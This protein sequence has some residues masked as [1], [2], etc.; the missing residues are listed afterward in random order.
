MV[1][2]DKGYVS[3]RRLTSFLEGLKEL[4]ITK[5]ESKMALD[6]KSQVQIITWEAND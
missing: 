5:D 1:E 4:F 2:E 6:E 3:F